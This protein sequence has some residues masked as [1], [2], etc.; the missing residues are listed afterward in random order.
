MGANTV[1]MGRLLSGR[2]AATAYLVMQGIGVLGW[3]LLMAVSSAVRSWF[4]GGST[5]WEAART[6]V[7][8]DCIVFGVGSIVVGLRLGRERA[9]VFRGLWV[10]V[11][12]AWYATLVAALWLFDPVG[13]WLGI[14]IMIPA[15]LAT[16]VIALVH[17]TTQ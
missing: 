15:A 2:G 17:G 16:T 12:A 4:V 14:V 7:L 5:G 1:S 10:L 6:L 11:G 8:A 3:W 13:E 9:W